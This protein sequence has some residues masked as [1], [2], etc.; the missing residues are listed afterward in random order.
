MGW[1]HSGR[2]S[3]DGLDVWWGTGGPAQTKSL[4]LVTSQ[5][6]SQWSH[7]DTH[8]SGWGTTEQQDMPK[9]LKKARKETRRSTLLVVNGGPRGL[10]R[11]RFA[12]LS[13][14]QTSVFDGCALLSVVSQKLLMAAGARPTPK[15]KTH[16]QYTTHPDRN[17]GAT[18]QCT[19]TTIKEDEPTM[20]ILC[21]SRISSSHSPGTICS[22]RIS[23]LSVSF[24]SIPSCPS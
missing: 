22:C 11:R 16:H 5:C 21:S 17:N 2:T 12:F 15:G 24:R 20:S 4:H 7:T 19:T 9:G 8:M 14:L 18:Q 10:S 13:F 1:C 3:D 6:L 23:H